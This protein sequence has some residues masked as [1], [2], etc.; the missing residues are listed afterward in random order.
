MLTGGFSGE[1]QRRAVTDPGGDFTRSTGLAWPAEAQVVS[2]GDIWLDI[3]G[4]GEFHLVFDTDHTTLEQ[5]LA[6]APPWKQQKW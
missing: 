6:E 5:W 4:D 3:V 2:A 1:P